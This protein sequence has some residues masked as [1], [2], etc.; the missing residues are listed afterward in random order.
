[1]DEFIDYALYDEPKGDK[2]K[3]D[4]YYIQSRHILK[5]ELLTCYQY[6]EEKGLLDD[7][8]EFRGQ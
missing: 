2:A 7:Y 8:K 6:L 3:R 4:N 1:M 5:S